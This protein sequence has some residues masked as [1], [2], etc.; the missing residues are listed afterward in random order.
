[1]A[2]P[3]RKLMKRGP[4]IPGC[5]LECVFG[6]EM[7]AVAGPIVEGTVGLIVTDLGAGIF[8]NLLARIHDFKRSGLLRLVFRHTVDLPRIEYGVHPVHESGAAPVLSV[9]VVAASSVFVG[10]GVLPSRL[11]FPEL[12]L[13]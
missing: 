10:C 13:G 8:E 2:G 3:V 5:V 4:V 11:Y 7:N 6:R 1:M 9:T 12:D